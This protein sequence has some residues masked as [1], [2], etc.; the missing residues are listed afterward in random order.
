MA[1]LDYGTGYGARVHILQGDS[2]RSALCGVTTHV[3][4]TSSEEPK[5]ADICKSCFHAAEATGLISYEICPAC[6]GTGKVATTPS[7]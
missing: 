3:A 7:Q 5:P 6:S 4:W 2:S 1:R